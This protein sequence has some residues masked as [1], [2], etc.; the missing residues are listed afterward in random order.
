MR[1]LLTMGRLLSMRRL[2]FCEKAFSFYEK[3]FRL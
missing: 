1:R 3:A 2:L